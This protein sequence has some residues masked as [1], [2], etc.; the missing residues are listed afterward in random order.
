MST[1]NAPAPLTVI[2]TPPAFAA[3]SAASSFASAA[4]WPIRIER[5]RARLGDQQRAL[6]RP[7]SNQTSNSRRGSCVGCQRCSTFS[8]LE[9]RIA[10]QP[11]LEKQAGRRREIARARCERLA[12]RNSA[13]KRSRV[14][15]RRQQ[16]AIRQQRVGEVVERDLAVRDEQERCVAAQRFARARARRRRAPR[17]ARPRARRRARAPRALRRSLRAAAA[18]RAS[19]R[20]GRNRR[21]SELTD[22]MPLR[23]HGRRDDAPRSKP[24]AAAEPPAC[25]SFRA[26]AR[27]QTVER[28]VG[29]D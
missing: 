17:A 11:R 16:E 15:R 18:A 5:R 6:R 14:E 26:A 24:R 13:S 21:K 9:R 8:E 22:E 12:C 1:E 10:R 29:C 27:E 20:I 23:K 19:S 3:A 7:R 25:V 2:R 4:R 28:H